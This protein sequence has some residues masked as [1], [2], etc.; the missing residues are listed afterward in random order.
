MSLADSLLA[1]LDDLSDEEQS[2]QPVA[3]SSRAG[4]SSGPG[5]MLP[6][7]LPSKSLKRPATDDLESNG[8][9]NGHGVGNGGD[10]MEEEDED[11]DIPMGFVPEGGVRPAEELDAEEV[12]QSDLTGVEDVSKVAKLMMGT[13]LPEVLAVSVIEPF[14]DVG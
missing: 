8:N 7:P 11:G 10:G 9:G 13:K 4:P 6:P 12:E 2:P 14:C 1:D 5:L 3:S